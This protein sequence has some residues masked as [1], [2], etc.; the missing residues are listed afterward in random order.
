VGSNSILL[1]E[2]DPDVRALLEHILLAEGYRVDVAATAMHATSLLDANSY[3]VVLTDGVLPDGNGVD[4]ADKAKARGM[5]A[6]IVTGYALRF[7]KE[8][9]ARHGFLRKPLRARELLDAVAR[10][11]KM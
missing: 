4:I 3:G 6:L 9:L 11:L 1:V 5:P 8:D 7:A 2:D 10:H